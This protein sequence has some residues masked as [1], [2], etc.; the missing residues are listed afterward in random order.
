MGT[1]ATYCPTCG[2]PVASLAAYCPNCGTKIVRANSVPPYTP[3]SYY[4]PGPSQKPAVSTGPYKAII[5]VLLIIIVLLGVGYFEASAGHFPFAGS[6][7]YQLA[8]PPNPQSIQPMPAFTAG[9]Y[10]DQ[11]W[12]ACSGSPSTGC[13][14][15]GH[16]WREGSVPDT[17]DYYVSF[18]STVNVTVYF[19]TMGQFV[20]FSVCNGDVSCVSG[21][22][23]QI[24]P[25]TNLPPYTLFTLG[26]GC[27]DYLAIYVASG[28][29]VMYPDVG[30]G[31]PAITPSNPT[32]YCAQAGV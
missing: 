27:A 3:P 25:T 4:P 32:G 31:R 13:T 7:R 10:Q 19:F 17:F 22:Y 6:Y 18:R 16:G 20:Q 9:S 5:V 23:D 21:S 26:E 29:G 24:Q 28:S 30:V 12:N 15:S 8:N 14:M 2:S 11:I 1:T